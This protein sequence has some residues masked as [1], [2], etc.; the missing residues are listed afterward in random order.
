MFLGW[1]SLKTVCRIWF[2]QKLWCC[3]GNKMEFFKEFFK[4]HLF[5]NR[6]SDFEIISQDCSLGDPL[7]N[8]LRNFDPLKNMAAVGVRLH[9]LYGH[10]EILKKSSSPKLLVRICNNFTRLFLV[11]PF[12]KFV[13]EYLIR[14]KIWPP[15]E[16]AFFT[17]WTSKKFFKILL[18]WN[19]LSYFGII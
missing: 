15:W 19:C 9:A 8:C 2:H 1:S 6:W 14:R 10:E 16:E 12:S 4:N 13:H 3:H 11:W 18:L 17:V 7:Q 5:W